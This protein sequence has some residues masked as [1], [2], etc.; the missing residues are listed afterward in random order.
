MEINLLDYVYSLSRKPIFGEIDEICDE[1]NNY[2]IIDYNEFIYDK[3]KKEIRCIADLKAEIK[4]YI[5]KMILSLNSKT[6]FNNKIR[7]KYI[8]YDSIKDFNSI[9]SR[10]DYNVNNEEKEIIINQIVIDILFDKYLQEQQEEPMTRSDYSNYM[11]EIYTH[12]LNKNGKA[13]VV[14]PDA[15]RIS[16]ERKMDKY[17]EMVAN[18][19]LKYDVEAI[20]Y[21]HYKYIDHCKAP[22]KGSE[23]N[24]LCKIEWDS[25]FY[26]SHMLSGLQYE[27]KKLKSTAESKNYSYI[28]KEE[29]IQIFHDFVSTLLAPYRAT[30]S[31]WKE[32]GIAI[33]GEN[34]HCEESAHEYFIKTMEYYYLET[35]K[36]IDFMLQFADCLKDIPL[37]QIGSAHL[38][39]LKRFTP[40]VIYPL[41]ES[42]T[43]GFTIGMSHNYYRPMLFADKRMIEQIFV[44]KNFDLQN[45]YCQLV[46]Y[47]VIRAKTYEYFRFHAQYESS[48]YEDIRQFINA[49]YDVRSF[50]KPCSIVEKYKDDKTRKKIIQRFIH[51]NSYLFPDSDKRKYDK[52]SQKAASDNKENCQKEDSTPES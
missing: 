10:L 5:N 12:V 47:Q 51:L 42:I 15:I 24:K 17:S 19:E 43:E 40:S 37:A 3:I 46:K 22:K 25:P 45:A 14:E 7:E 11:A 9:L 34:N 35:Y 2:P 52:S 32:D 31:K 28:E 1:T 30:Y 48:N 44:N 49:C 39:I 50:H 29:D 33:N 38:S 8:P 6:V 36:R 13:T 4:E 20:G 41:A 16:I 26:N 18:S 27:R 23:S 21:N